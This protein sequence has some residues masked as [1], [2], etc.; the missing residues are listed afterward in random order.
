MNRDRVYFASDLH[1]FSRR[2][3]P[4]RFEAELQRTAEHARQIILGG[5]IFDFRWSSYRD[6]GATAAAAEAWLEQLVASQPQCRFEYLLGNHDCHADWI[7]R[8]EQLAARLPNLQWHGEVLRQGQD[9]F[10]HGDVLSGR[11][12]PASLARRR[13]RWAAHAPTGPVREALYQ[14]ALVARLHRLGTLIHPPRVVAFRLLQYLKRMGHGPETGLRRVYFGHTHV[15]V[16]EYKYRDITFH[17][18]GAP[19]AGLA[20]RLVE[21]T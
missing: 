4:Q 19:I 18:G 20:F 11:V 17:N 14:A 10:L 8:L 21:V 2:S 3:E 1:L 6:N 9:A 16:T 5:D 15:A 7:D 12:T 13:A